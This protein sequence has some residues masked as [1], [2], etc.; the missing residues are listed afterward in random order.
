MVKAGEEAAT[1]QWVGRPISLMHIMIVLFVSVIGSLMPSILPILLGG[2][3]QEGRLTAEQIGQAAMIELLAIGIVNGLAGAWLPHRKLRLIGL[4]AGLLLVMANIATIYVSGSMILAVRALSGIGCGIFLWIVVGLFVR[5]LNPARWVGIYVVLVSLVAMVLSQLFASFL[6][7]KFGI[8]GGF[9]ALAAMCALSALGSLLLP[10]AFS[11]IEQSG[12]KGSPVP[13]LPGILALLN[14]F[15]YVAA[16]LA[17]WVYVGTMSLQN[18]NDPKLTETAFTVAF[19]CQIAGGLAASALAGR[20][21]SFLIIVISGC[22]SIFLAVAIAGGASGAFYLAAV[23]LFGG[24]WM[25][26]AANLVPFAVVA[27]KTLKAAMLAVSAQ[28]LGSA[29]GPAIASRT[30]VAGDVRA[31]LWTGAALFAVALLMAVAALA[32]G[33]SSQPL[34]EAGR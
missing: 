9:S 3:L 5:S 28:L 6:V 2:L 13:P 33:R 4:S 32:V 15:F 11:T 7:P 20:I 23:A 1:S 25:F 26:A 16:L 24:L 30:V 12:P 17:V 29:A 22:I 31:A 27:D 8:N 21:S 34:A 19:G 18:G 10:A 14:Q